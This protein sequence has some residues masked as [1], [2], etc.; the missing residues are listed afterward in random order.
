M[1]QAGLS[2]AGSGIWVAFPISSA[3]LSVGG[4]VFSHEL[5]AGDLRKI[6]ERVSGRGIRRIKYMAMKRRM[7]RLESGIM[8]IG[9]GISFSFMVWR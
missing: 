1:G 4:C 8:N 7:V 9:I 5:L 3:E 2:R 6:S